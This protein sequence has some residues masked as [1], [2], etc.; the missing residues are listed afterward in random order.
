VTTSCTT[1]C[2]FTQVTQYDADNRVK[3]QLSAYDPG[4]AV[5]NTPAETDYTYDAAGRQASVSAPPSGGQSVRKVTISSY[6]D[7]GW[8]KTSTDPWGIVTSYDYNPLGQQTSRTITSVGGDLSR[9][10]TWGYYPDGKLQSRADNG[11]PT[12]L[13]AELVDNS[14]FG[15]TSST[16]TWATSTSGSGYQGY[17][18]Q[19]HAAGSGTD[20][21]TW[22]LNIPQDGNYTVYVKYP[23]VS[24]AATNASFKVNYSGGSAA[25][26][27]D[28]TGNNNN[29]WVTLGKWAFAQNGA[30]Q[31]VTLTENSGGTV[32]ADAV[33]VVRDNSADT[34]TAYHTS[35]YSYDPNG[36]LTGISDT[37]PG[38]A[39][40]TYTVSYDGVDQVT[41][42]LEQASGVTQHT[43]TFGYDAAGN[44]ASRGHDSATSTYSYDPR[45]LLAKET[46]AT[47]SSDPSPQ[48]TTFTF[49]PTRQLAHEVKA[50]G[51]TVDDSYFADG[52]L[53]H[54][55]EA[56]PDGTTVAEHTY[57]YDPDANKTQDV[58]KLMSADDNSSYLTHTLGYSYDPRD[59]ITQVTKDGTVTES[60]T[61]DAN[62]N[63]TSQTVDG[64]TTAFG[65]DRN[66]LLTATTGGSTASYNY[67]PF[68]RLDT[69]TTGGQVV[70]SNTY[71]GFDHVVSHQQQNATGGM[72]TTTYT[73][74]PLDRKTSETTNAGTGSAKTTSYAYLGLSSDLITESSLGQ[75]TKSYTYSPG[76]TRLSQTTQ[77][78]DG[79]TTPGY[80]TYN[81]H[82]D[83]EAVTGAGGNTT[84]TY[85]YTAYGQDDKAQFTGADK[86]APPAGSQPFNA[87]RFNAMRWDS[88]T[89]QYDM[90]FRTYDPSL[91]Q[92][93]SRDMYN[94]ALEDMSL[95][96]DPFTGNRY[97]FG[98]GNPISNI[99]L[100]GHM[101][102][103]DGGGAAGNPASCPSSSSQNSI[104]QST[105][106]PLGVLLCSGL[107]GT[108]NGAPR[109][110]PDPRRN[111]CVQHPIMCFGLGTQLNDGSQNGIGNNRTWNMF[112][113]ACP[114][115]E[116]MFICPSLA[117]GGQAGQGGFAKG[118]GR[119][120]SS[121]LPDWLARLIANALNA[122]DSG[123]GQWSLENEAM[124]NDAAAYQEQIAG[125]LPGRLGYKLNDV[126][127]DGYKNGVLQ[128]AKGEGY[129]WAVK[130]GRF[131]PNYEGAQGLINQAQNQLAAAN[132]TPITWSVAEQP[133]A[134]AISNLFARNGI[135]GINVVY[136]PPAG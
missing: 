3:A 101:F 13:Y 71:D 114:V 82:S 56:K 42:V 136:V 51:N 121:A 68:G 53:Q 125:G 12:G 115:G 23:V 119:A 49:G 64:A 77:N 21:F 108:S 123:P 132:G 88:S 89:A 116:L 130:N 99:E 30:G 39:T 86:T 65:Y 85:G 80:Y 133:T 76:G 10:Q 1:N 90:G 45:N 72:D 134:T 69:V 131:I 32:V 81:D 52:L 24:G 103:C 6:F 16:G 28:Q 111:P 105:G 120:W 87:Y 107:P 5:Y 19:T 29:G 113:G 33:K 79:T 124:S 14:D 84:A 38:T 62:D 9:T 96:T 31:K 117:T 11:V 25:V 37:S 67:D 36:N 61:H 60:Y 22:N 17:N 126:V 93:L 34:N 59:R 118:G 44:L 7:N 41:K 66:R 18:Y 128:E 48:V 73:Y 78:S 2:A 40:D 50:N 106:C 57:T 112:G 129:A 70:Q 95:D 92:F 75:T 110:T 15:N 4:D 98:A 104:F 97:T 109:G 122:T 102:P 43:T 55:I 58:E 46:D 20:A 54:Q 94:G 135:V 83:V 8:A 26:A 74:D 63:V 35:G 100:D 91:N 47:S 27:V 127:F